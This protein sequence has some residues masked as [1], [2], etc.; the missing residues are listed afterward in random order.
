LLSA[1]GE[2]QACD[3]VLLDCRLQTI[4]GLTVARK[5][6]AESA[7]AYESPP[8]SIVPMITSDELNATLVQLGDLG[9]GAHPGYLLKP[10]RKTE[11][12]RAIIDAKGVETT[13]NGSPPQARAANDTNLYAT[14][15]S[16]NAAD[17][18]PEIAQP[19]VAEP[20][21][22]ILLAEDSCDNQMLI[23]AYLKHL[24]YTVD[25]AENGAI[26][27][28]RVKANAYDLILM[29]IQMPVVDGY[30]AVRAIRRWEG[31]QRR[32]ALPIIALTASALDEAVRESFA[33][34][35]D[36]HV[37]KP[38][39]KATLIEAI[40]NV[41]DARAAKTHTPDTGRANVSGV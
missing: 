15:H 24:N 40:R 28:E 21:L 8:Y 36:A 11:L 20:P 9:I 4:D 6:R 26:A 39:R 25:F 19:G 17:T 12:L 3:V 13:A 32:E 29:D 34:G 30:A 10:V 38:V 41:I 33:A 14:V 37:S 31:E 7:G 35:C 2:R 23:A 27:I 18:Q 1:H 16:G 22:R 5:L